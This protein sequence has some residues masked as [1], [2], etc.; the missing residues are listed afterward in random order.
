MGRFDTISFLSDYGRADEF[1]GVVHSVV[2]QLAP[3]VRVIDLTHEIP[4]H[5][6]RAGGLALARSAQYLAPGVVLAVVDPGVGSARRAVAVEVGGGSSYLVGPDNGLLAPAVAMV[7]GA[8]RAVELTELDYQLPAPGPTFAGRDVFGPAAAHLCNG[9]DLLEL[10]PELD[11]HGLTPGLLPVAR[12]EGDALIA[13]VL[14]TDGFGNLQ[15]NVGPD[16]IEALGD[17]VELRFDGRIRTGVRHRTYAEVPTG[18][19]GLVVDSY[20]LVSLAFD[21]A[22]A[23]EELGIGTG[24]EVVLG[25]IVDDAEPSGV[26]TPVVLKEKP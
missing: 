8:T 25:P 21:R 19:V 9:V 23:A 17:R 11:V 20:G 3:E 7:G 1:V 16:E 26:V 2:R 22:S 13:E 18:V 14:W 24:D 12:E 4:A 6:V 5:D 10:G 15:L